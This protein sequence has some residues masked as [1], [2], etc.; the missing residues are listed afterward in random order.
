MNV[1]IAVIVI[2]ASRKQARQ[3]LR[4]AD[5][6]CEIVEA[7]A[8]CQPTLHVVAQIMIERIDLFPG[9]LGRR[10]AEGA[11]ILP[12]PGHGREDRLRIVAICN[13]EANHAGLV[14][15]VAVLF[16]KHL[17]GADNGD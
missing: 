14:F 16:R 7:A 10:V 5:D 15:G 1:G 4:A 2:H 6:A 17:V 9:F 8:L 11:R 12:R 3:G 13:E